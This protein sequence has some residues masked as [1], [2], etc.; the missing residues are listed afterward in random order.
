[1]RIEVLIIREVMG[2]KILHQMM[3]RLLFHLFKI[4]VYG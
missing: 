1:M 3:N 2:W 4:K